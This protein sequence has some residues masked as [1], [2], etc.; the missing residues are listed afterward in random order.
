MT[1]HPHRNQSA[2]EQAQ[3]LGYYVCQGDYL[4]TP[5]NC[6]G[7]WYY[8]HDGDSASRRYGAGYRTQ[9]EAWEA[10]LEHHSTRT[11]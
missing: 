9:R 6:L 5:D 1:N 7:R 3:G 4:D 8:G 2:R 11:Q 10:A